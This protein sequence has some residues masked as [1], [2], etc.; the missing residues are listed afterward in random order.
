MSAAPSLRWNFGGGAVSASS[1][2]TS[3]REVA[4]DIAF[5]H[6][7]GIAGQYHFAALH[8]D[9]AIGQRPGELEIL[10]HQQDRHVAAPSEVADDA[11][12]LLDDRGLDALGRLVQDKEA[13]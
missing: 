2:G 12:D 4:A 6:V 9:I 7:V 13:R 10:L 8:D 3:Y 11:L 5:H 1:T